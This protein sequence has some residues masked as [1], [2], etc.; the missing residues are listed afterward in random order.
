MPVSIE[1]VKSFYEQAESYRKEWLETA[2]ASWDEIK[3]SVTGG[4]AYAGE[5]LLKKRKRYPAWW[6][7]YKIRQSLVLSRVGIPIGRDTTEAG[8]DTIGAT[9]ALLKERLAKNLVKEFDFFDVLCA[10]RDDALVTNFG[11]VRAYYERD[12]IKEPVKEYLQAVTLADGTQELVDTTGEPVRQPEVLEDDQGIFIYKKQVVDV[13]QERVCLEPL[14]FKD[15]RV[16]PKARRWNRVRRISFDT[17]YSKPEF[18]K[19][20][21]RQA[22]NDLAQCERA[23]DSEA[24]E[25]AQTIK[26]VEY[27][28]AYENEVVWWPEHGENLVTPKVSQLPGN[29]D[30]LEIE[31]QKGLYNL[32]KFF[33]CPPPLVIN[34]PTDCF[35]P[36]PEYHQL[37]DLLE[38]IHLIFMR[39]FSIA[40]G[41][42]AKLL[43]DSN[44]PGLKEVIEGETDGDSFGVPN[45]AQA[46]ASV[47]GN[48]DRVVQYVNVEPL[49]RS[50]EV[51]YGQ[52][53]QRLNSFYRLS[54]T[55]DLLQGLE[56]DRAKDRTLGE[57]Q[58]L[59]KHALNQL[60]E[61]QHKMQEFVR[62]SYELVTDVALRN[63]K[64]ESLE[65]YIIPA[66]LSGTH[67]ANY[68]AALQLLKEED[69]RFRIELETDSTITIN[70][71]YD[72]A[73]RSELV[74]IMT[75]SI[76]RVAETAQTQPALFAIQ[77]H[78][79]KFLIQGFRHGKMFQEEITQAIDN[80]IKEAEAAAENAEP[81][82]DKDQAELAFKERELQTKTQIESAKI[83]TDAQLKTLE[84]Q[85]QERIEAIRLQQDA[86]LSNIQAQIDSFKVQSEAAKN[87]DQTAL[88]L[89][90][91]KASIATAQQ[92]IAL[93]RDELLIEMQ[94]AAG[95]QGIDEF[96]AMLE[97]QKQEFEAT[98]AGRQQALEE[99]LGMLDE[100]EKLLTEA[101]L[102]QEHQLNKLSQKVDII[103]AVKEL[104]KGPEIPPIT[105]NLEAPKPAKKKKTFNIKRDAD[106]N[107]MSVE[108]EDSEGE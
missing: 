42:R 107:L 70:E 59:E 92:E 94:K 21:G 77:L 99:R 32:P 1:E 90:E 24:W 47:G 55:S 79:L 5:G 91:I 87:Q 30:G 71:Q 2:E 22:F 63:F 17:Y 108:A 62:A 12:E 11:Q 52:L 61:L 18:I 101:R 50:L 97:K 75:N 76:Q 82:F 48:L 67:K 60:A 13:E 86:A 6:S 98:L 45:L 72:K 81:A 106:G 28:D 49:V 93:K 85:S 10:A 78:A 46:L 33:P 35:W 23:R 58:M 88:K 34:A 73:M 14:L 25:K 29:N 104:Q 100:Q 103:S 102:Q 66:T 27:W 41:I 95:Q 54:G 8:S 9:A 105:V 57:S 64:D 26:V 3:R 19:W 31:E 15:V 40:N 96:R 7:A 53:E 68:P 56:A 43:Y 37:R 4:R 89:E 84:I 38:E 44:V 65:R 69:Q 74:E 83:N 20:F 51:I 36:V 80:V 39:M 16:D